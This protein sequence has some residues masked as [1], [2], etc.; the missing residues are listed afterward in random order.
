MSK[1]EELIQDLIESSL[2]EIGLELVDVEYLKEGS[3]W[4]LR[5]YIDKEDTGIEL[6]DCEKAS[7]LISDILD[8]HDP[9]TK[10]YHLEVSSPGIERPLKKTKDFLRFLDHLVQVK[11]YSV[12]EKKKN[13]TGIL[14]FADEEEIIL[15]EN[16]VKITIPREK[17]AKA[18]LAWEG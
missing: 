8:V 3:E 18:N 17:I 11:T 16:D 6:E 7:H 2:E 5:I 10:A 4:F 13:F 15:I 12:I 1:L 14:N 9:I